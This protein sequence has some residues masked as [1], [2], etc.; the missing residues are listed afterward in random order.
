[1]SRDTKLRLI[2]VALGLI[3]LAATPLQC[4]SACS[5]IYIW[6]E[7][8]GGAP[9]YVM[10]LEIFASDAVGEFVSKGKVM[11]NDWGSFQWCSGSLMLRSRYVRDSRGRNGPWLEWDKATLSVNVNGRPSVVLKFRGAL[12]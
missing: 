8:F 11:R 9:F 5:T 1:M 12:V 7:S 3:H 10:P 4:W 2:L 6:R